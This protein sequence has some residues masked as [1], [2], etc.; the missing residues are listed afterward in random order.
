MKKTAATLPIVNCWK[1]NRKYPVYSY[2]ASTMAIDK[3]HCC[4]VSEATFYNIPPYEF[5]V[6]KVIQY[7]RKLPCM[8][9]IH[10]QIKALYKKLL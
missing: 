3:N 1:F 4:N 9:W 7:I 10:Q 8:N 5:A 2:G 6:G